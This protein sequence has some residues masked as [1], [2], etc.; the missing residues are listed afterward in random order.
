MYAFGLD[1]TTAEGL[2]TLVPVDV[3]VVGIF[4]APEAAAKGLVVVVVG[5]VAIVF[6]T[7]VTDGLTVGLVTV[8]G[9]T[10]VTVGVV[11]TGRVVVVDGR[12]PR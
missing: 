9:L 6:S 4:V 5:R 11:V 1:V 3:A 2:Y 12:V 7:D 10:V 8:I